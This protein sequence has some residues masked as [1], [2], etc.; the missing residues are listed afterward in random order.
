MYNIIETELF[1]PNKLIYLPSCH[2]T[3]DVAASLLTEGCEEGTIVITDFQTHGKGQRGNRWE[4]EPGANLLL[5]IVLKPTFLSVND[6]FY[7][8]MMASLAIAAVVDEY[9]CHAYEV[10]LKWPNDV[11]ANNHK[12]S[13]ILIQNTI[14][15]KCITSSIL[16]IGLNVNQVEFTV[17]K[18]TSFANLI[19]AH[20][21]LNSLLDSLLYEIENQYEKLKSPQ[22]SELKEEYIKKLYG[23]HDKRM[24]RAYGQVFQ[25]MITGIDR[26]GRLELT[27]ESGVSYFGFKEVEFLAE[28]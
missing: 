2:S 11:Y 6:Q 9:T 23:L 5:S 19:G 20:T 12:I 22:K 18:A 16:G 15:D 27:T 1:A 4:S 24:Y 10:M 14:R 26:F 8:N 25:A 3:N 7:L 21:P 17:P 13:G 28:Y